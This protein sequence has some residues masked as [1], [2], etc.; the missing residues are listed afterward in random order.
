MKSTDV[1]VI[2][3]T[4]CEAENLP[5][6]VPRI[7]TALGDAGFRAEIVIVDDDSPD[8]TEKIC[9]DLA[10]DYPVR[11]L[12]RRDERGLSSAVIHG[13]HNST[14]ETLVVM[15]ADLSHPPEK[16]PDLVRA[17]QVNGTDFVIGSRYVPGGST[18]DNWGLFRWLN[19]K[20]ATV[21]ARPF[22]SAKDP[23]AGFFAL[24]RETFD[25]AT[26][27]D[28]IGYK[29]GLELMVK[30][31]CRAVSEVPI[32]FN[33][34]LHGES[35]L[36]F[37]EQLNYLRHLKRLA[38]FKYGWM[39]RLIQFI[40]VG[41]TGMVVDLVAYMLLLTLTPLTIARGLAIWA[42]MSWNFALN[43]RVTFSYA[44]NQPI[45]KQY[46][47]FCLS[48]LL[49]AIINWSVS[50]GLTVTF[51]FFDQHK[52]LAAVCGIIAGTASNFLLSC[53]VVFRRRASESGKPHESRDY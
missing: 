4:Y 47:F 15:D 25:S 35:K 45:I 6:L 5:T 10:K 7:A 50:V 12:V 51:E 21:M 18:D 28:P 11:C 2:V 17:L 19:S 38:D 8:D 44:R 36:T 24:R 27:L 16:V 53:Q 33:D 29:I 22:T 3:P 26:G 31:K 37:K 46:V 23:M 20:A 34:R 32:H 41:A 30:A 52:L 49:G 1:S 9:E 13:M 42:A 14:G 40:C 39:S 43:R 48:C